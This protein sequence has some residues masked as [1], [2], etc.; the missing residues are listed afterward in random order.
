ME[1]FVIEAQR[2]EY[3]VD[4]VAGRAM[5]V[6]E[7]IAELRQYDEDCPVCISNDNGYTYGPVRP[8]DIRC[9]ET[10]ETGETEE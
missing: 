7:L 9:E 1:V 2:L 4:K 6:G 3:S 10:E 8:Y 5:T